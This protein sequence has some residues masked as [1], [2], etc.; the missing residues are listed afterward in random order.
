LYKEIRIENT[1]TDEHSAKVQLKPSAEVKVTVEAEPEATTAGDEKGP[2]AS[3]A[4][5]SKSIRT[6][7]SGPPFLCFPQ[8]NAKNY[9]SL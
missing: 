7:S 8:N 2:N 5:P 9:A 6:V 1:L 3:A 4:Y